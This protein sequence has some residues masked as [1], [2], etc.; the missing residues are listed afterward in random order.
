M[1]GPLGFEPRV[2]GPEPGAL[3]LGDGPIFIYNL[4]F[5]FRT[6]V[7]FQ[8]FFSISCINPGSAFFFIN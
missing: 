8:I 7:T 5:F 1:V 3:P 4:H 6:L 2:P